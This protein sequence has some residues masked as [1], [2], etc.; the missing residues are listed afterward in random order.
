M[1]RLFKL[2]F[3]FLLGLLIL[4]EDSIFD[5]NCKYIW[6]HS[7]ELISSDGVT[8]NIQL[9]NSSICLVQRKT[10]Y[11]KSNRRSKC[12]KRSG[13]PRPFMDRRGLMGISLIIIHARASRPRWSRPSLIKDQRVHH[14][15]ALPTYVT[16]I[17]VMEV[18]PNSTDYSTV[19]TV[20]KQITIPHVLY[21]DSSMKGKAFRHFYL[22]KYSFFTENK[23]FTNF[24]IGGLLAGPHRSPL[25]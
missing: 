16:S 1:T 2:R 23:K 10:S 12:S 22:R 3:G 19:G 11:D 15:T 6:F 25:T 17:A 7:L 21:K 8:E 20:T 13:Q 5:F 4:W 24:T 14:G 9:H 18:T